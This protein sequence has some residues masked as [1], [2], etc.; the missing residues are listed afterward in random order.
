MDCDSNSS[1]IILSTIHPFTLFKNLKMKMKNSILLLF[2]MSIYM[3]SSCDKTDPN[4]PGNIDLIP[5]HLEKR[6]DENITLTNHNE[7]GVDYIASSKIEIYGGKMTIEPGVTILFEDGA[8]M[9][10]DIDGSIHAEGTPLEPIRMIGDG[11][12]P[13]WAGLYISTNLSN[14]LRYVQIEHAGVGKVHGVFND[15]NAAIA[16]DGSVSIENCTIS[17]CGAVGIVANDRNNADIQSFSGN[18]IKN[19]NS[20]PMVMN[21]NH[22]VDLDLTSSVFS[23]NAQN[24]IALSDEYGDRLESSLT[25]EELNIPYLVLGTIDLYANL[26]INAG[27]EIVMNNNSLLKADSSVDPYL[28]ANGLEG[29]HVV[30]RGLETEDAYWQGIY[31]TSNNSK[32]QWNYVDISDGGGQKLTFEDGKANISIEWDGK[33][34]LNNCT[35]TRSGNCEVF[36]SKFSGSPELINNSP[37]I[38]NVCEG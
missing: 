3:F 32:N 22:L 27:V 16:I 1:T 29:N 35:S 37:A 12:T 23:N 11:S 10:F 30:I 20:Y 6:Y 31:I 18:T 9:I 17:E 5:I 8:Y 15:Y 19:C 2:F 4:D 25:L 34:E 38:T 14:S 7:N 21:V 13:T 26:S 28:E 36:I 33:L 24:M